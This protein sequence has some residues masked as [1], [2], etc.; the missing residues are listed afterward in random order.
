MPWTTKD[1]KQKNKSLKSAKEARMW[2][3]VAN[4]TLSR[5]LAKGVAR[6][7]AEA[8]AIRAAN[9]SVREMHRKGGPKK[10]D[11]EI[12][13]DGNGTQLICEYADARGLSLAP[14]RQRSVIPGVKLLGL[15]SRNGNSYPKQVVAEAVAKYEGAKVNVDHDATGKATRSYRDRIGVIR[16][17]HLGQGDAGLFGDF[18]LNPKHQL[19]EQVF[20][21]AENAPENLGFSHVIEARVLPRSSPV[22][23]EEIVRV[24]SVD[25]VSNPA[26]TRGLFEG[27][28]DGPETEEEPELDYEPVNEGEDMEWETLTRDALQ[29]ERPDLIKV[30]AEEAVAAHV[31]SEESKAQ[32][33]ELDA[34]INELGEDKKRL[35]EE[36]D[37][38]KAAEAL[39]AKK[40]E[41]EKELA[42]AKVPDE[43]V[44]DVFRA[45]LL[46]AVDIKTRKALIDDR[47]QLATGQSQRPKSRDQAD[48]DGVQIR[49]HKQFAEAIQID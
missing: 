2:A 49:D 24:E 1:A 40:A 38:Y 36:L 30:I 14:D 9:N 47:M 23:V 15:E 27:E 44:T 32:R 19:A 10:E 21:D 16:N 42:E 8:R 26:T 13:A 6:K 45:Q 41:I 37:K 3:H 46:E 11:L 18:H 31:D 25:L 7:D 22:K 43:L 28:T 17:P 20:W 34:K 35:T 12:I 5:L 33:A 48:V 4:S 39:S 29:K